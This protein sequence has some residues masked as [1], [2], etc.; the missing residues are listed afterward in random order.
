MAASVVALLSPSG[1]SSGIENGTTVVGVASNSGIVLGADSKTYDVGGL[2]LS[3]TCKI[4]V[5]RG[6]VFAHA[7]LMGNLATGVTIRS[8][9][10]NALSTKGSLQD[11]IATF[12]A[13]VREFL[14]DTTK[15]VRSRRSVLYREQFDGK[16]TVE[17]VFAWMQSG[18]PGLALRTFEPTVGPSDSIV[19]RVH[20][21]DC[22]PECVGT[23]FFLGHFEEID[24]HVE[25]HPRFSN[26]PRSLESAVRTLIQVEMAAN[27]DHVGPPISIVM[28]DQQGVRWSERNRGVCGSR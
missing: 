17:A 5:D 16:P 23:H 19:I 18:K 10:Q 21:Q 12:E 25:A 28:I 14:L 9:A 27:P 6:V 20:R 1:F 8:L 22:W 7:G 24:Q 11:R 26:E 13:A 2:P 15:R 3:N 4:L